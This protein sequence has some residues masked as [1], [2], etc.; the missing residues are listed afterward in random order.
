MQYYRKNSMRE[1][2]RRAADPEEPSSRRSEREQGTRQ[3]RAPK[4][5]GPV[6]RVK[7]RFFVFLAVFL[8]V[9]GLLAY[10]IVSL[11][12]L[13]FSGYAEVSYGMME[14]TKSF[15]A[16]LLREETTVRAEG[17]GTAKYILGDG[18]AA[19]AGQPVLNFY[20]SGYTQ[21]IVSDLATENERINA[22]QQSNLYPELTQIVDQQLSSMD[23]SIY[24]KRG[25]IGQAVREGNTPAL[26]EMEREL[27]LLMEQKQSYLESTPSAQ[28]NTTLTQ[29]YAKRSQ[30]LS[31][32]DGW[33]SE[34]SAPTDGLVS[35]QLDGLEP[36]LTTI[37]LEGDDFNAEY[38]RQFF[39]NTDPAQLDQL[40][41]RQPLF[42]VV[43]ENHWYAIL[44]T[45]D[46]GWTI[47]VGESCE[48]RF[49][50]DA[51]LVYEAKVRSMVGDVGD[52]YVVLEIDQSI[53]S[54]LNTRRETALIGGRVE[55]MRVPLG[56]L[57]T[58][59]GITGVFLYES[60]EFVPVRVIGHDSRYA[61][62]MPLEIGKLDKSM[63]VKK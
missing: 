35:Y 53:A 27:T 46:A 13:L 37:V 28:R 57:K 5:Q 9:L 54:M 48:L 32:I 40:R 10:G 29:M 17:Y 31:Q 34:Y 24:E 20:S 44:R 18:D 56:S 62:V 42:R 25:Q 6:V 61:L 59:S 39:D 50:R 33:R 7:P 15:P 63:K 58:S 3:P 21:K 60:N 55:G 49:N 23:G 1:N 45:D 16:I 2:L 19:R 36:Y 51:D 38:F 52:L 22:Q 14:T 30:I 12:R 8:A 11:F 41:G 47:G 26:V 4:K 43:N